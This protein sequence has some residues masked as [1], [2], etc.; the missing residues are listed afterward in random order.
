[1]LQGCISNF[2][3]PFWNH[4]L[5][6]WII[7]T[8]L[9]LLNVLPNKKSNKKP[10]TKISSKNIHIYKPCKTCFK[11]VLDQKGQGI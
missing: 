9:Y 1:M 10:Q 2:D 6:V 8:K 4:I 5:E 11:N 7:I 3:G